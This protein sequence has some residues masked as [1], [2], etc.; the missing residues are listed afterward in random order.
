MSSRIKDDSIFSKIPWS[1][2][3]LESLFAKSDFEN[4][5]I[6]PTNQEEFQKY[7]YDKDMI[8][9]FYL[10][11]N[12]IYSILKDK[13]EIIFLDRNYF[14]QIKNNKK[15]KDD[16]DNKDNKNNNDYLSFLFYLDLLI[17]YDKNIIHYSYDLCFIE[18][19]F[20]FLKEEYIIKNLIISKI[21]ITLIENYKQTDIYIEEEEETLND[22]LLKCGNFIIN[23]LKKIDLELD[24]NNLKAKQIDE[25]Y[26]EI[27][28]WLFKNKNKNKEDYDYV[29]NIMK[30][31]ELESINITNTMFTKLL[32]FLNEN[33]LEYNITKIDDLS[34]IKKK[35]FYFFLFK[36]ILKNS[37]FIYQIPILLKIRKIILSL[38]SNYDTISLVNNNDDKEKIDFILKVFCD[39]EYYENIIKNIS[40]GSTK[41]MST[42]Q[43]KPN[44]RNYETEIFFK[45]LNTS[46]IEIEIINTRNQFIYNLKRISNK[47]GDKDENKTY[48]NLINIEKPIKESTLFIKF[49]EKINLSFKDLKEKYRVNFKYILILKFGTI[50][51]KESFDITC[52]YELYLDE[53]NNSQFVSKTKDSNI[54][55]DLMGFRILMKEIESKYINE[56][57]LIYKEYT[58]IEYEKNILNES[59]ELVMKLKN[60]FFIIGTNDHILTIYDES[61][62]KKKTIEIG[63]K[64]ITTYSYCICEIESN[65]NFIQFLLGVKDDIFLVNIYRKGCDYHKIYETIDKRYCKKIICINNENSIIVGLTNIFHIIG[66]IQGKKKITTN[67]IK[68]NINIIDAIKIN[69]YLVAF[70]SKSIYNKGED[71]LFFYNLIE[72]KITHGSKLDNY[73]SFINT[74]NCLYLINLNHELFPIDKALLCSCKKNSSNGILL[75]DPLKKDDI[76]KYPFFETN[77]EV[78]CFCQIYENIKESIN[79]IEK[80]LI[81]KTNYF[82]VGGFYEKKRIGVIHLYKLVFEE[83]NN[84]ININDI[85]KVGYNNF[86]FGEFESINYII[87]CKNLLNI[88]IS[89]LDGNSYSFKFNGEEI[90]SKINK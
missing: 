85:I 84:Q 60:G 51:N 57:I 71:K 8:N 12:K 83:N 76:K 4:S 47:N 64:D 70:S 15:K 50:K 5:N 31:L 20:N 61:F 69:E 65:K 17:N 49:L 29:S 81:K 22:M 6:V 25:I 54:S 39:S 86:N 74:K 1:T 73:Y 75:V 88:F 59:V 52:E 21:I 45:I 11:K 37:F 34:D 16:K 24:I 44:N 42:K 78:H 28:I 41:I 14:E 87:Q 89:C 62:N 48:Y 38:K 30:E 7:L 90:L 35:N 80:D 43:D 68:E 56:V 46:F 18:N 3:S 9:L 36:Y 33:Y 19:I 2:F 77:F 13:D 23:D 10:N 53:K 79:N 32:T 66:S 40:S 55:K 26:I 63:S 72:K 27:I 82:L 58:I 67:T